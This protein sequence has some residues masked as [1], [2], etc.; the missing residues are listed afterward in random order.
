MRGYKMIGLAFMGTLALPAAAH[1][2]HDD[3]GEQ[4]DVVFVQNQNNAR[5][6]V[7]IQVRGAYRYVSANGIPNHV[8]GTFPNRGNP[9]TIR[10]QSYSYRMPA[11]PEVADETTSVY[12]QPFGVAVNG[13][14][15]DPGTAEVWSP[16]G[17][18]Q[19]RGANHEEVWSY[20]ALSGNIDLGVD[21]SNAHVQPNGAYHYHGIPIGLV[22]QLA[23][24]SRTRSMVLVGYAADGFPIYSQLGYEEAND[25]DSAIVTLAPSFRLKEGNRPGG[26]DA[27]GGAYDGTFIQDFEYVDGLGDLDECNGRTGVT[28]EYPDGT[29]YYVLT[30]TYPFIPRAFRGTPDQSFA[31]RRGGPPG[32]NEQGGPGGPGGDRPVRPGGARKNGD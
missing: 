22:Q 9:N 26:N 7:T 20:D 29:Y 5:S 13:V 24:D 15:F 4:G 1:P 16:N 3:A 10:A 25:S 21:Q 19:I 32:G 31:R 6:E 2:G 17:R 12:G 18:T 14:P 28:P 11:Q 27:P 30:D 8:T 23:P